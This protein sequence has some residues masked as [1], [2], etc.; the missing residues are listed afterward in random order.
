MKRRND[1]ALTG[2]R[3]ELLDIYRT[4]IPVV[5]RAVESGSS[6]AAIDNAIVTRI[7]LDRW[8]TLAVQRLGKKDL[9]SLRSK[10]K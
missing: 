7:L 4:S 5:Q 10:G 9:K 2:T 1:G 6:R 3:R 8:V